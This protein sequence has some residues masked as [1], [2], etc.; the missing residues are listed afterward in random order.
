MGELK[1]ADQGERETISDKGSSEL[2]E[3]G[4]YVLLQELLRSRYCVLD[5]FGVYSDLHLMEYSLHRRVHAGHRT[6]VI[7]F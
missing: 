6:R 7:T 4:I 1:D 2:V 3:P 5:T